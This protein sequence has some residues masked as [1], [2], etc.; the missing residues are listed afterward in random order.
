METEPLIPLP[1]PVHY[2]QLK[3]MSAALKQ[4]QTI[5]GL[6]DKEL[7]GRGDDCIVTDPSTWS[8]IKRGTGYFPHDK[9][10]EFNKRVGNLITLAWL[11][12]QHGYKLEPKENE[13]QMMMR[14]LEELIGEK[15]NEIQALRRLIKE[16]T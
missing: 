14:R 12:D 6:D 5:S 2:M 3:T 1:D 7:C 15:N 16:T 4:A 8:K 13:L 10:V 11:A 9:Y